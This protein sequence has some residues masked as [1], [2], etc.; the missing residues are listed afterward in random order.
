MI[1]SKVIFI[2]L[3]MLSFNILHDSFISFVEKNK[4]AQ[5][6]QTMNDDAPSSPFDS[7]PLIR[8]SF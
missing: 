7:S 2:V 4:H 6:V 8:G 3:L 5:I 1:R